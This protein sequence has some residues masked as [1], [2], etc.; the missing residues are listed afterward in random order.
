[1]VRIPS[2]REFVLQCYDAICPASYWVRPA[3]RSGKYHPNLARGAGGLIRHVKFGCFWADRISR[4][5]GNGKS[6]K[7]PESW[8]PHHDVAV[9]AL[10]LHDVMKDGNPLLDQGRGIIRA[11]DGSL[12][13]KV[14]GPWYSEISGCHGVDMANA[15]VENVLAGAPTREQFLVI[16]GIAAHMGVWTRPANYQPANLPDPE[17][18]DVAFLV[19]TADY[20]A[21]QKFESSVEAIMNKVPLPVVEQQLGSADQNPASRAA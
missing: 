14:N 15:I 20:C 19:S 1:M 16:M 13:D 8:G 2:L 4:T 10:I 11:A 5:R 7:D 6:D 18:R 21:A 9:A 12:A 17:A 3:S